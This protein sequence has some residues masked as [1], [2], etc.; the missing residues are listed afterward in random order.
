MIQW[1]V[2]LSIFAASGWGGEP[3]P[4]SPYLRPEFRR[5]FEAVTF[6][7][8]FDR[9]TMT[10]DMAEGPKYEP[11][12]QPGRDPATPGPQFAPGLIGQALVLGSGSAIY[13]RAGNVLLERRGAVAM[14]V[15]PE[16]WLRPN[17]HNVVF[18][19]T[20]DAGFYLE[21]QGPSLD[22]QGRVRAHETVL[23]LAREGEKRL[24]SLADYSTWENGRWYLI[25]ANWSWPTFELSVNGRPFT[26]RGL[27]AVPKEGT[28]GALTVGDSAGR[29]GLLDEYMAFRRPLT[30]E[31][32]GLLWS[33]GKEK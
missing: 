23:Y 20:T 17:D 28:F 24:L 33:L 26:A 12:I 15:R 11:R 4:S 6:H 9:G 3:Q 29:R 13:P 5:L 10:P 8:S 18:S 27:S 25:V 14:W 31:E 21:R 1:S 2:L 30:L 22:A 16:G 7:V 19:M 32:V